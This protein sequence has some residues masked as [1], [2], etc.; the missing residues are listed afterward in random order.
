MKIAHA[1]ACFFLL[2]PGHAQIPTETASPKRPMTFADLQAMRR[3]SDPQ[4]SP[5]G[6]WVLFSVV[7]VSLEKNTK[8]SHLW[9]V[10]IDGSARERQVTEGAGESHGR[11]SPDGKWISMTTGDQIELRTWDEARGNPHV[12]GRRTDLSGAPDNAIWTPDSHQLIFTAAVYPE[13]S[14]KSTWTL[15]EACNK[16]L[17]RQ[18]ED[19]PVKA[20]VWTGL[21]Y[22]HWDGYTGAKRSHLFVMDADLTHV[23][24][25][26]PRSVVGDHEVPTF[27]PG[28]PAGFAVSPDGREL[29]YVAKLD[30]SPAESTRSD[31]YVVPL[32]G[33]SSSV[34]RISRSA[35]SSDG[36]S[37]SPDGHWLAWRSQAR[38]GFES[39]RFRLMTIDRTSGMVLERVARGGFDGSIDEFTW[40]PSSTFVFMTSQREGQEPVM[41]LQIG[42]YSE[43]R[44]VNAQGEF[45]E[46]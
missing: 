16:A 38:A 30:P 42:G 23:R 21:L 28:G 27:S 34:R 35:G 7:D 39:D 12:A 25:M 44:V 17:D 31:I 20:Q 13:C 15:E 40:D 29:A 36:L 9:V 1:F 6:R 32:A 18:A 33:P 10:P 8:T 26:T 3:V 46:L 19:S 4:I 43:L 22:R 14:E 41:G 37:Y 5:S 2:A 45:S 24:D 11:F